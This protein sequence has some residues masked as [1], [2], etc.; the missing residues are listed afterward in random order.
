MST[1]TEVEYYKL[2]QLCSQENSDHACG[3]SL[4]LFVDVQFGATMAYR[5][6]GCIPRNVVVSKNHKTIVVIFAQ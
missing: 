6:S 1:G 5:G 4:F 2:I 3:A